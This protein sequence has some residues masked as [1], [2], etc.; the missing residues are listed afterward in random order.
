MMNSTFND[1]DV[2]ALL[3][4]AG[5]V[6]ELSPNADVHTRRTHI[7]QRLLVLIGGCWAV[8]T[9]IDRRYLNDNG[10]AVPQSVTC[11][12][13]LTSYQQDIVARYVTGNLGEVDPSIP[14]L[15]KRRGSVVT[16]RRVD[17]VDHSWYRSDHFNLVRRPI[18]F[19]ESLYG[20]LTTPDG[21]RLKLSLHREMNDAPFSER[22]VQLLQMFN[23][24][25]ASLYVAP[26]PANERATSAG[27]WPALPARLRPVL[28]RFLAGDGEKQAAHKLGLSPHTVHE[29]TKI[30]YRTLGVNSRGELLARFVS[31]IEV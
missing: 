8:C 4:I 6:N 31:A 23:E 15:L 14:P 17:V 7:L 19:G 1:T 28:E 9:E 18:G 21:R 5:E 12:G 13:E 2:S 3:R 25:L 22:H 26:R 10:W 29:Y 11:A 27:H 20:L 24:N 30:L 16:V